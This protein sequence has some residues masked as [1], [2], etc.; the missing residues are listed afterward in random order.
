V[1]GISGYYKG[2]I[3]R[4]K[5]CSDFLILDKIIVEVKC[6]K[7]GI[8]KEYIAQSINY[9]EV[10]FCKPGLIVNFG[11]SSLEFKRLVL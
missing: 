10:Y 9:L 3:L 7:E 4:H 11:K 1:K 6:T 2:K 5:F 8:S